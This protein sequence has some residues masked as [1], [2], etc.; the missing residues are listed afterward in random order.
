MRS[1][2]V[3]RD[4]QLVPKHEAAPLY[5]A[6]MIHRD[7]MDPLLHHG[8]GKVSD[9]KS[10][11]RRWNKEGGFIEVGT[12]RIKPPPTPKAD[13]TRDAGRAYQMVRDGYVPS[14]IPKKDFGGNGDGWG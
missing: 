7:Q 9:S 14:V 3:Y 12:E 5:A 13:L 2:W 4:G 1:I 10:E 8:V 11:F 6:P